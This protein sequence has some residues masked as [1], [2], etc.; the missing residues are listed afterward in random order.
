M[1]GEV[2]TVPPAVKRLNLGGQKISCADDPQAVSAKLDSHCGVQS[3]S[4]PEIT[5]AEDLRVGR[6]HI[7]NQFVA[8]PAANDFILVARSKSEV[9]Q[10][11]FQGCVFGIRADLRNDVHIDGT[12]DRS[13]GWTSYIN[14]PVARRQE[15]LS[16]REAVPVLRLR[17]GA[18]KDWGVE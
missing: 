1:A 14:S 9:S 5:K 18:A 6:H 12:P 11:G 13:R 2:V 10:P 7:E 17:S 15:R 4:V 8:Y 16:H 3:R